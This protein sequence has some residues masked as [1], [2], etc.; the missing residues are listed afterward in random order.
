MRASKS[1]H[2]HLTVKTGLAGL[3]GSLQHDFV[4]DCAL[5]KKCWPHTK[6][7]ACPSGGGGLPRSK[8]LY[9]KHPIC[10]LTDE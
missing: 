1:E 4:S 2:L 7:A 5:P 6:A 8:W 9:K 3:S 10:Q